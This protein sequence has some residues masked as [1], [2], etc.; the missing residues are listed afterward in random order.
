VKRVSRTSVAFGLLLLIVA[1]GTVLRL[2]LL[3]K[4]DLWVDES[5]SVFMAKLPWGDF[6]QTLWDFQGNMAPYY[7]LLR[8]WLH[9]GDSEAAVRGLSVLFGVAVIPA[10]YLLG[11]HLFGKNAAIASAAL[12]AVNAFQ[13]RYSQEARSYSLVMLLVVLATYF[14]V[15][16]MESPSRKQYWVGYVLAS[17]LGVYAHLF[18]YLV[19][20]VHFVALGYARLRLL[21]RKTLLFASACFILLTVPI[22]A[23]NFRQGQSAWVPRPTTHLVV[24]FSEVLTGNGGILLV[25]AYAALCLVALFWPTESQA[26]RSSS[27]D[28]RWAVRLVATWLLFPIAVTLLVDFLKPVF[29][30]RYMAISAPAL[31]LLAGQGVAKLDQ[32]SLRLGGLRLRG[33]FPASLLVMLGLSVWGVHRYDNSPASQGDDWRQAI[34]YMLAGQQPGDAV[35]FYRGSGDWPFQYYARREM[36]KYGIAVLPTVVF[37]LEVRT[38]EQ[39]PDVQQARLAIQGRE[40]VWLILQHYEAPPEREAAVQAIQEALQNGYRISKE[41]VFHGVSG[42]IRVVLYVRGSGLAPVAIEDRKVFPK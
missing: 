13:I 37:P 17:T 40:R 29:F 26:P 22:N 32:V 21:P 5:A 6:W 27:L 25:G 19:I 24:D 16:I 3:S 20:A 36:E 28:E 30:Y 14:F 2:H 7:L 34:H 42:P 35:F 18:V 23:F 11:K 12:S 39:N 9:L 8:G 38:P 31:A 33:L 41:E 10:T 1:A 15:R 4:R